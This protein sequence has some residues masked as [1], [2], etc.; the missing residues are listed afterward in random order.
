M[1][2]DSATKCGYCAGMT[3]AEKTGSM[4]PMERSSGFAEEISSK[5]PDLR[6]QVRDGQLQ[7][8]RGVFE[9]NSFTFRLGHGFASLELEKEGHKLK[10]ACGRTVEQGIHW[11][12]PIT[13]VL[14]DQYFHVIEL[15]SQVNSA[16]TV[17][18]Q[19]ACIAFRHGIEIL[20]RFRRFLQNRFPDVYGLCNRQK[21]LTDDSFA[22]FG[23]NQ[24]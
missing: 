6:I 8:L 15:S 17:L 20:E 5:F 4:F 2:L 22:V 24:A 14:N 13:V 9:E 21:I 3:R 19:Q 11:N 1:V 18:Q 7:E 10:I 16:E 23:P 12:R